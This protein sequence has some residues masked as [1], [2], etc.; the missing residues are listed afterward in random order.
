[1]CMKLQSGIL[2]TLGALLFS[3]GAL[4]S[5]SITDIAKPYLGE[6]RCETAT[7]GGNDC[8]GNFKDIVLELKDE[9]SYQLR[10]QLKN[11]YKGAE[12]GTYVYDKEKQILTLSLGKNGQWKREVPIKNGKICISVTLGDT[13][14]Y[15]C[16]TQK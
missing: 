3:L 2:S 10:Y 5:G 14:L 16:F 4:K 7:L 6:Y 1:M 9:T 12:E 8:L 15:L 13:L 11:G